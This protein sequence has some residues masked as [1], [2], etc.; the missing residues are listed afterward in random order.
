VSRIRP[1]AICIFSHEGKILTQQGEDWVKQ[2]R[3]YRPLGGRIE[4]GEPA[5]QTI[6]REI[7]EEIGA[8]ITNIQYLFTLENIFTYNGQTGHEIVLVFDAK[9]IDPHFYET[10]TIEAK[11][12]SE[13]PFVAV[14]K[15]LSEFGKDG[16]ILYPDGLLDRIIST[17]E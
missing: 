5:H 15:K 2:N 11:E 8:E 16:D 4:F 12:D 3:F 6:A 10:S 1:I 9:F 17:H 14:W 7:K 13:I